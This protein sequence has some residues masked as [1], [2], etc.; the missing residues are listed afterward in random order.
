MTVKIPESDHKFFIKITDMDSVYRRLIL[1]ELDKLI[2]NKSKIIKHIKEEKKPEDIYV[3][4][5][6]KLGVHV[7]FK[8]KK[9]VQLYN[10]D[11]KRAK[12]DGYKIKTQEQIIDFVNKLK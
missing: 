6:A 11:M 7:E 2:K 3:S 10:E 4:K 8:Y 1:R 12:E 5:V 9:Y